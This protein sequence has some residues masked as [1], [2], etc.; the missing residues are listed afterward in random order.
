MTR[1]LTYQRVVSEAPDLDFILCDAVDQ[2]SS[3][4]ILKPIG[5]LQHCLFSFLMHQSAFKRS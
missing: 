1:S 4:H 3:Q 2:Q 5:L